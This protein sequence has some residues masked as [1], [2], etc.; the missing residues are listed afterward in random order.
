MNDEIT[1]A[2]AADLGISDVPKEEQEKIIA[3]FGE[4]ALKAATFA[5]LEKMSEAKRAEFA[6]VA[7]G[8]D[9]AALQ[10]FLN[11]EVPNHEEV[12]KQAVADEVKRFKEFKGA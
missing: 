10:A 6:T 1:A 4:V 7:Q 2:I 11:A 3:Q 12:A 8:G 9:A 5:I